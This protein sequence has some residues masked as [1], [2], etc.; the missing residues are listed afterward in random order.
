VRAIQAAPE[1]SGPNEPENCLPEVAA[2]HEVL[3]LLV[4]DN[5]R[6]QEVVVRYSGCDHHGVDDG[7]THRRLTADVL[8]PLLSG[9]HMP[10]VLNGAVAD[11]IWP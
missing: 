4:R 6:G 3:L 1:G 2:G 9:P 11:L 5:V 7:H 10:T 8:R